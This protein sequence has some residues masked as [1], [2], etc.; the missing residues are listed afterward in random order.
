MSNEISPE[1]AG[2]M[3]QLSAALEY[4]KTKRMEIQNALG[5]I[6][7]VEATG[8]NKERNIIEFQLGLQEDKD[9]IF[10][11]LSGHEIKI[12][13]D[14]NEH[15]VEPDDDRLKI[16][17]IY[18]V[19][20]VMNL[21]SMYVNR[22][23]LLSCHSLED[24]KQMTMDFA[25]ELSDLFTNHYEELLYYPSPEDLF[26]RY[27]P[28]VKKENLEIDEE[29]LYQKCLLWSEEELRSK[30]KHL[31]IICMAIIHMIY[32]TYM[33]ALKGGE[34]KSL[35]ERGINISQNTGGGFTPELT[36]TRQKGLFGFLKG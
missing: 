14:N 26:E 12:G 28:I 35:G 15:W 23:K 34:R 18:G 30:E 27:K 17:S 33:R 9:Q 21:L 8:G 32:D 2:Y 22:N 24:I 7:S 1:V 31:S 10:H 19:K 16:F 36:P 5:N 13:E 6:S 3:Q 20:R 4:E 25:E 11:L 29:E